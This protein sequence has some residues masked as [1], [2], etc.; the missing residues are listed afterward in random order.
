MTGT[1]IPRTIAD[2]IYG[3]LLLAYPA[4]FR[5]RFGAGMRY[6][7][8]SDR[9][10]ARTA[11][12]AAYLRF[13]ITTV[14]DTIRSG[15]GER[16]ESRPHRRRERAK[17]ASWFVVDW[18]DGWRSLRAT[19]AVT[20]VAV[21]SLALGIG[22]NTA[23]FSIY[24][25]LMLKSLPVPEADRLVLL[26]EDSWTNPIWEE[27]RA[28]QDQIAEG[29]FAWS[30][31]RFNLSPGG[32]TDPVDGIFASG[33]IFDVLGVAA[34]RGRAFTSA[35]DDRSG[36]PNG[37]VAVI[38]YE[39]WQR[40]FAGADDAVGRPL[41]IDGTP[42]TIVGV[43]PQGFFGPDVGRSADVMLPLG[44]EAIVRG[45]D[46]S[47]GG[48]SSWWLNIMLRLRRD[49]SLAQLT[50]RLRGVQDQI[51][52][53]T[54]PQRGKDVQA[55][56]LRDP[57]ILEPAASG[58]STLR[59]RYELP[60]KALMG[61]VGLV[62]LIAC[63]NIANLLLARA[64]ARR[65]ELSV[66]LALGASRLRLSRQLLAESFM[67]A[68]A[69][70]LLGLLFARWG[71]HALV[72]QLSSVGNQVYLEM[73]LDWRV[74]AF[75]MGVAAATAI[76]FGVAPSLTVSGLSPNEA[77]KE[78]GRGASG[79]RRAGFRQ[80]LVV[81][82]VALSLMLVVT[83]SLFAR[84]LIS[85]TTR[86]AGFDR[87]PVLVASVTVNQPAEQ[88]VA[89]FERLRDAAA[90]VPGVSDAAISLYTPVSRGGWNTMI[91][92]PADSPLGRRERMSW[93][94]VVSQGWFKA[95]GIHLARGRDFDS[96]DRMGGPLVAVVNR[97]F[98]QRFLKEGDPI[99]QRFAEQGPSGTGDTFEV[100]GLVE[101]TVYRS[102]R[103]AMEPTMFRPTG[104]WEKPGPSIALG[105][106]SAGQPPLSLA[107]GVSRA[108]TGADPRASLTLF[109]L[110]SHVDASLIQ[111]RLLATLSTFFGG[112]ALLLASLGLYGVTS[113]SV[114]RRRA[115][116]GIRMALG[117]DSSD[118]VRM[119]LTR[120][121]TLVVLGI[122][123][124]TGASV[125]ASRFVAAFLYGFEASDPATFVGAALVLS[126]VAAAA[127]WLPARRASRID[128]TIVLR[129]A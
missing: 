104:Q 102:L 90:A 69:G 110:S 120:V 105:I 100:V 30:A 63:A 107:Q 45:A 118:V 20:A 53:A 94:N 82:Q 12:L 112:L 58:R 32:E 61:V 116:I 101:D 26:A 128:P 129:D 48:R 8:T 103:S 72:A 113:Y 7:F 88:R 95:Y 75:T 108:L 92:V 41:S 21:L 24:N 124:G 29:A 93:I 67:L 68:G 97:A 106:R 119:V 115:E 96:R 23:L 13:W 98:A 86:D 74:L 49:Q 71:S 85:L 83:A 44:T 80:A 38:S 15:L 4:E 37:P 33:R 47:L 62:L 10:T 2:R 73:P 70:T 1:E 127:G 125:W 84:T 123:I 5:D 18:R 17:M 81:L 36:G 16:S 6:A 52:V 40:R 77:L 11:G 51:R 56:Y 46:S 117:A 19:P 39:L 57:F 25:G 9:E 59:A 34:I 28:R 35:D 91:V 89:T 109:T 42:F 60:L 55:T 14:M 22:A 3:L 43:M 87:A 79:E 64:T 65:H 114:N 66:R 27:I 50:E 78:Q 122:A 76:L 111:E 54:M 121:G 31:E 126:L 99:G